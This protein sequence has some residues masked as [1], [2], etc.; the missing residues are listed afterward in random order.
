[1]PQYSQRLPARRITCARRGAGTNMPL[2]RA[3]ARTLRA[4]PEQRQQIG[5]IDQPF[6][7][8]SL[9]RCQWPS[10]VLLVEKGVETFFDSVWKPQP[11]QVA[12]QFHLKLNT[13]LHTR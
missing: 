6:G 4:K 11:C 3:S 8:A 12:G 9:G 5:Q 10:S 1:M 13:P 7:F 2:G